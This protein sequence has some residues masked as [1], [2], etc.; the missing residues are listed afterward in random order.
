MIIYQRIFLGGDL[1][2]F[3]GGNRG[4]WS[5]STEYKEGTME[6]LLPINHQWGGGGWGKGGI[7]KLQ[8][9]IGG[10]TYFISI[11]TTA[12]QRH[13]SCEFSFDSNKET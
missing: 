3:G 7:R 2:V 11:H 10:N 6:H 9:F 1:M 13:K 4:C 5:S 12:Y 8:S